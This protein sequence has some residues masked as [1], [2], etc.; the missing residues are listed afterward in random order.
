MMPLG[1]RALQQLYKRI[2]QGEWDIL[3]LQDTEGGVTPVGAY[4]EYSWFLSPAKVNLHLESGSILPNGYHQIRSIFAL[5]PLMDYL[6]FRISPSHN[7]SIRISGNF[8]CPIEKNL[9]YKA[10][11][12]Y[13]E[14]YQKGANS[15]CVDIISLKSIPAGAGLG[16]GSSNAATTLMA[17]YHLINPLARGFGKEVTGRDLACSL[18]ESRKEPQE[19]PQES[20]PERGDL[21]AMG[22]AL[23]ADIPFFLAEISLALVEG[24]G[25]VITPLHRANPLSIEV[26]PQKSHTATVGAY[27][28]IDTV[29]PGGREFSFGRD[30]L[31]KMIQLAPEQWRFFNIFQELP[32]LV[33]PQMEEQLQLLDKEY[34][35]VSMTGTG[36]AIFGVR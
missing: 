10:A 23:G 21:F 25:E 6:G 12:S 7:R 4:G 8:D 29:Y 31:M 27:G 16:G 19:K 5:A 36:S 14:R 30:D 9:I 17:L 26:F 3:P 18:V 20:S 1:G 32:E 28:A 13:L 2:E 35:F 15:L 24:V 11:T 33:T 22:L 34:P